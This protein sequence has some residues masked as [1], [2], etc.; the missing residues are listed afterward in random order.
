MEYRNPK[1]LQPHPV[2]VA[3]YG[4]NHIDDL[5]ES[6]KQ[7]GV[8]VPLTITDKGMIISGHRR[9]RCACELSLATI[10]VEVKSFDDE[11]SEKK[12]ILDF[13]KQREKT[14]SQ[15]MA[16]AKLL[17][18]IVAE[19]AQ[20]RIR[21]TPVPTLAQGK[22]ADIVGKETD[23]GGRTTFH[24]AERIWDKAQEGDNKARQLVEQLD[25]EEIT[26][27]KAFQE[28]QPPHV[29]HNSGE[30]EWYTPKEY[31]DLAKEVL[32]EIDLDPASTEV[33]N[34]LIQAKAYYTKE[35]D[36]LVQKWHGKIWMNPP[37]AQPLV[38]QFCSKLVTEYEQ[39]SI[40]EAIVLVN[41]ATETK[42]FQLLCSVA[43]GI[44]FPLGRVRFWSFNDSP[45]APLQ[46][47][48]LLYIG[49]HATLFLK[50]FGKLGIGAEIRCVSNNR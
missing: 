29:S 31:I 37:Y 36:G 15:K 50:T 23:I 6:I 40:S 19:E 11:L 27:N 1:Q 17:K 21:H 22:T 46:G 4:D 49:T 2:S 47:Q 38:E 9:W 44:C 34:N 24:K 33:A 39:N 41:N 18:E 28:I 7:Y 45:S 13:N 8:L 42:W 30:N 26:I 20:L 3:L 43:S 35:Q 25:N 16:E 12:A 32:G 48:A 5:M 10:P 14:F